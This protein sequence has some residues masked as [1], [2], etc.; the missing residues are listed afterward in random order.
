MTANPNVRAEADGTTPTPTAAPA[1]PGTEGRKVVLVVAGLT[2][3]LAL[4]LTAFALPAV[5]SGPHGVGLG[6]VAPPAAAAQ[7][8]AGLDGFDVTR[9]D[10]AA[11]ARQAITDR[12]IYGALVVGPDGLHTYVATAASATVAQTIGQIG[13][14]IA[15][16]QNVPVQVTDVRAFP[17]NDPRGAGLSAGALP[18]ALGGWIAAVLIMQ[19]ISSSR[20]RLIAVGAFAVIGGFALVAVIQFGLGTFDGNYWLTSL[21]AMLGIAATAM[22]VLGLRE[23]FGFA[24]LGIA[25]IALIFLGNPLSGLASAPE[26]LPTPWGY[27]GQLLPP[28]ATGSLLRSVA[29]F[30]GHGGVH[31][32]IVLI[33]WLAGGL[34]L[35]FAGLAR[36]ARSGAG[37]PSVAMSV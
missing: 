27:I 20:N 24:G 35:Y 36:A 2:V 34:A 21:A 1:D 17:D 33:C 8:E 9:Y 6:I 26:M 18:L 37:S 16:A 28:G 13:T 31:A 25:A 5:K 15:A 30:D 23:F 7:I 11:A 22:G 29:F 19:L 14:K 3:L 32:L 12:E 10:D 4:M